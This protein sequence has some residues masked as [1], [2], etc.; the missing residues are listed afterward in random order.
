MDAMANSA[1]TLEEAYSTYLDSTTAHINQFKA[2]FEELGANTF[3]SEFLS[4]MVDLG[5][6]FTGFV[7]ALV[8]AKALIPT[9]GIGAILLPQLAK[10]TNA[11]I[12]SQQQV[13]KLSAEL[14]KNKAVNDQLSTSIAALTMQQLQKVEADVLEAYNLGK[15]SITEY[16]QLNATIQQT[17][18]N[19]ELAA[20]NN[21][22]ATSYNAIKAA[23][24][25]W[26]W[27]LISVTLVTAAMGKLAQ[28]AQASHQAFVES[29]ST[30]TEEVN[31]LKNYKKSIEEISA[32]TETETEKLQKLNEIRETL[33]NTYDSNLGKINN[34]KDAVESLNK[35]LDEQIARRRELYLLETEDEYDKAVARSRDFKSEK[36]NFSAGGYLDYKNPFGSIN[37]AIEKFGAERGRP[38]GISNAFLSLFPTDD[39][40][41]LTIGQNAKNEI[42]LLKE[43]E[44]VLLKISK[45]RSDRA[46]VGQDLTDQEMTL[47]NRIKDYYEELKS[48]TGEDGWDYTSVMEHAQQIAE[49]LIAQNKQ[50]DLSLAEWRNQLIE[51][52]DYD[53]YVTEKIMELTTV[54]EE[55]GE[56]A[57]DV[58][59]EIQSEMDKV[60]SKLDSLDESMQ[61]AKDIFEDLAKTIK[62]NN[63]ADKFFSSAEIID[64]LDKYPELSNAILETSYGYKIEADALEELRQMKLAEQ[65]DALASQIVE[66]ESAIESVQKRLDAYST[67]IEGVHSLAEAKVKLASTEAMLARLS[68]AN[69]AAYSSMQK[70][71]EER[72]KALAGWVDTAAELDNLKESLQKSKMQYTVL[73]KVFDDVADK[74]DDVSKALTEQKNKLKDLA[75]DYKDAQDKIN[76]LIKLTM[77]YL[78]KEANLRKEALK[79]QLDAFK[80]LIDKRKELIDLEKEQYD[81]EKDLKEQNRDLLA[82]QQE[83]DALSIEG[84]DYSLEDMK[85]KAELQQKYNEQSEKRTDFLY[86]HEVDLRKDALDREEEAF[87]DSINTQVKA[88]EDY[89]EHEG[90]IRAEAIDLINSKSEEFYNNLLNYTQN[91][92]DMARWEFQNL[93]D[94]A[95]EALMKYGNGAIDVD[96][97]LA[98]LAGRI[99]QIDAEMDA[100]ENQINNTKNAA[101]SFT[102][103]FTEGMDGVVKVTE[104]AINKMAEL[105]A[106]ASTVSWSTQAKDPRYYDTSYTDSYM[107]G[108]SSSSGHSYWP[109]SDRLKALVNTQYHDGG[110]VKNNG[111][112]DGSE[113][114]AKLMT[115]E[116]VVTPDQANKFI[117]DTLPKMITSNS[118]NNNNAPVVSIGDINIAGDAT[119]STVTKIKQAQKEIVD[120]VFKVI[121]NQRRLYTGINI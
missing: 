26:G 73:G 63:D 13:A 66:T 32:S 12:A 105:N 86:D 43:Y 62:T 56:V 38:K 44:E 92:T 8:K 71:L 42:E 59:A 121:N 15:L 76:D 48:D 114:L 99:A 46:K 84:A 16:Q 101:Q 100:L 54:T 22:V 2:A 74:S 104:E 7:N 89:L 17:M 39:K 106:A 33:N 1:G 37:N 35:E 9:L 36:Y 67:E 70:T 34:E 119:E 68:G 31:A 60:Q 57:V 3:K 111:K 116:V 30:I 79:E 51:L 115:G 113:I 112:L 107:K 87:E 103:G 97:T 55:A 65:K 78:K 49:Q 52:A 5:T 95:Y 53:E 14:I 110:L 27:V 102:D 19:A 20:S 91:Y 10:T 21:I 4:N 45:I 41:R 120:N 6:A 81:F 23:I 82:I 61:A 77:D 72:R 85:R 93:W 94:S 29:S 108:T 28:A 109:M 98:Y 117:G 96:Y 25:G 80:K 18:A 83:L 58:L 118:I 50:G 24:P 88:I 75:D 11:A 90:K 69:N 40:G 47:Y 64:L